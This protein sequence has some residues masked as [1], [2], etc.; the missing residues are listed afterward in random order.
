MNLDEEE[1]LLAALKDSINARKNLAYDKITWQ[2]HILIPK[3]IL[4]PSGKKNEKYLGA[5]AQL[6]RIN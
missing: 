4:D 5:I 3:Y 6:K 2:L 1:T